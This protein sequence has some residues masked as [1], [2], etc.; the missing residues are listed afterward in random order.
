LG[1]SVP[2]SECFACTDTNCLDCP[3]DKCVECSDNYFL[4]NDKCV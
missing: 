2:G 4:E 3:E 1:E